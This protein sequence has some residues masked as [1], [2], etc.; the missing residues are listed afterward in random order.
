MEETNKSYAARLNAQDIGSAIQEWMIKN[1]DKP[2]DKDDKKTPS[3][4]ID[5][6][7]E[8]IACKIRPYHM[9]ERLE[10]QAQ[11]DNLLDAEIITGYGLDDVKQVSRQLSNSEGP[12]EGFAEDTSRIA[13]EYM[14]QCGRLKDQH[15]K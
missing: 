10:A 11:L 4:D 15:T 14:R 1:L 6:L 3:L 8:Y 2:A 9:V 7:A 12:F 13:H 5:K